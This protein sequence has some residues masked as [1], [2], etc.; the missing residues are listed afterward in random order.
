MSIPKQNLPAPYRQH[1]Y[2]TPD[3]IK[4]HNTAN[5]CFVS[6]FHE[7][8]DLTN[9]IQE[10][11]SKLMEPLIKNAG[12]DISHW[13]DPETKEPKTCVCPGT[14]LQGYFA[15]LGLYPNI[16]PPFPDSEWNY[17][18]DVPWWKNSNFKIG[19]L[20]QK[21]RKINIMN[22]LTEHQDILEV[23]SEETINE[24]LDRY[25]KYNDHAESY[26]WKRLQRKL[27]MELTLDEN[28]V[29]DQAE[30]HFAVYDDDTQNIED[31]EY[32]P[33]IHLYFDD[34]LTEA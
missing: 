10:N 11:Y 13:F 19:K 28:G 34:D 30:D 26:T 20:T 31:E 7:V 4:E 9:F 33:I 21:V 32:I 5:D 24:I 3:E 14:C 2:Y 29:F 23:C 27:D 18:F 8:Y 6:I 25:K 12:T 1:R 16:P 17:D 22:T 15:P